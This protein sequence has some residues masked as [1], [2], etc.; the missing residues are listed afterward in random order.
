MNSRALRVLEYDKIIEKL[1]NKASSELGKKKVLKL[2]PSSNPSKVKEWMDETS[3]MTSM[4]ISNGNFPMG[5][6]QGMDVFVKRAA[7]GGFLYPG[8]LLMVSDTLR[9]ARRVKRHITKANT[10]DLKYPIFGAYSEQITVLLPLEERIN[11]AVIGEN[12]L[13]DQASP[14]LMNIR[15]AIDK[16]N[17]SIRSKL[18]QIVNSDVMQKYLQDSLVT[19]R[20]DRFV[21]PVRS[22]HKSHIKGIV[23]DRSSSGNTLYI[24]PMVIVELNN[25]LKELKL[26][27]KAEI[28]RILTEITGDFHEVHE[29]V[30][31]NQKVLAHLDFVVAKAL[32]SIE[33]KGMPPTINEEK[34]LRLRNARH[35]FIDPKVVVPSNLWLGDEFTTLLIT[36]PNTGGKTV[37]L[38]TLGLLVLMTQSGLHIPADYGTEMCI[39]DAVYAD[40]GDEQSIEQSLSTFSSHMTNIVEI[41]KE[42][43]ENSLVLFDELGAGTDPTEGAAL[44]MAILS[45]LYTRRIRTLA[46]THYSEL[47][48]FAFVKPGI[49]NASVEFD[50]ETLSPT[51][52]L[53][54][55]VPGKSNAFEISKKLGLSDHVIEQAR[56]LV[57]N[58]S[59][60]F[61]D[62]L[63]SIEHNRKASEAELDEA[64]RLRL[65]AEKLK[66]HVESKKE[67]LD[68]KE[69]KILTKAKQEANAILKKA[70]QEADEIIRELRSV[71]QI[72]DKDQNKRIEAMRHK[73]NEGLSDTRQGMKMPSDLEGDVP[74]NLKVGEPVFVVTLDQQ[75]EIAS[76]PDSKGDV[77]VRVGIMKMKVNVK[78]LRRSKET[79]K[80]DSFKAA[81]RF[82]SKTSDLST[83]IDVRGMNFEDASYQIEKYLDDVALSSLEQ[84]TIIH[85]KGTGVLKSKLSEYFKRHPHIQNAREG[86]YGEGGS[87]VT[88]ITMRKS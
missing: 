55:G 68:S 57:D 32:L 82:S 26:Q 4:V 7:I 85:G 33:L 1:K 13:S 19:I 8:E 53:L 75:G 36:G 38:K 50:V 58:N 63:S 2:K 17:Q 64:M 71:K 24:E 78:Q 18:N 42:V 46:T 27:E 54:I 43:D 39:F 34:K 11:I 77:M 41:L 10:P 52:K 74:K 61:E 56:A 3:E 23:H 12:E 9:T 49:E 28:E 5:P 88:V 31:I 83:S 60:E 87:G 84:V 20:D 44:A 25:D 86:E 70:K 73:L 59:I 14:G 29:A 66:K 51:Y 67:S 16:K 6:F 65:D 45:S 15:R 40:I 35:P 72:S 81:K 21:I 76:E 69:E 48:H 37:T 22:E 30:L 47:K 79:K 62:I 80:K